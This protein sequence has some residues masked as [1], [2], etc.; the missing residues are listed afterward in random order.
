M[1][2]GKFLAGVMDP[3]SAASLNSSTMWRV[4]NSIL[5]RTM[6]S[7]LTVAALRISEALQSASNSFQG[8]ISKPFR[9]AKSSVT[10]L[11]M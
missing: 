2:S 10:S 11:G 3:N 4:E 6:G 1:G 9:F 7:D 8:Q 5:S